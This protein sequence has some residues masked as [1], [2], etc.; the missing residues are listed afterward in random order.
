VIPLQTGANIITMTATDND[1]ES[2]T[3][4]LTVNFDA[5]TYYL[6]EGSTGFFNMEIALANPHAVQA[7]T[8]VTFL[9]SDGSTIIQ[10]QTLQPTSQTKIRVAD[11][12]G[13][14][15]APISAIV[16]SL[17]M[18]PIG[19]ERTMSWDAAASYGGSGGEAIGQT[20]TKWLFAEGAQGFFST[21]LLLLNPNAS[22]ATATVT[23]LPEG[24]GG[25]VVLNYPMPATSRLVVD[26]A[27]VPEIA[28]R[29]FGI[30][31]EATQPIVAERAM[32][33]GN[34]PSIL[35]AGGSVSAGAPDAFRSWFFAEGATGSF[36][37]TFL[38][39]GNPGGAPANVTLTYLLDNGQTVTTNKV[40][41]ANGR[42]T[43]VAK[44]D[45]PAL[46]S[47]AFATSVTS[48]VPIVA[49][50][51]MYWVGDPAPWTES[52]DSLG[53]AAPGTKWVLAEGRVGG[54]LAYQTYILLGNPSASEADVTITYLRTD[55]TTTT[56]HHLVP[57]MSRANVLVNLQVPT[58]QN[59]GFGAKVEVTN[60]VGIVVERSI[61]WNAGGVVWAGGTNVTATRLP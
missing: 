30:V 43:V 46:A 4:T 1:G 36:F 18:L 61:Y 39:I 50:R 40:V 35:I 3:D 56:S 26:G 37:D 57:G 8:S 13:L 53:V 14:E 42:L 17:D 19:V 52:H 38:L 24:G 44:D 47:A 7:H 32:Y 28:N 25:P 31:V 59:E 20:R 9:R 27:S 33:F 12:A 60:G 41:P 54:P 21:F 58:L 15:A 51:A 48:D 16:S 6:A 49:E 34:S 22:P 23:F 2:A 11:I 10:Q 45:A 29:S 55:G 5:L